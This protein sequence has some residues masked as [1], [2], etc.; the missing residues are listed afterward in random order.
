MLWKINGSDPKRFPQIT[1]IGRVLGEGDTVGKRCSNAMPLNAIRARGNGGTR[2]GRLGTA[3]E[4]AIAVGGTARGQ[5]MV[6]HDA[7]TGKEHR[8][9]FSIDMT[10]G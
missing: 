4:G 5:E 7:K 9:F 2:R 8:E 1:T 10:C 3:I 6:Q